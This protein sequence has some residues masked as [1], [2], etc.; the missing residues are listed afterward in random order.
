MKVFTSTRDIT[1]LLPRP[2]GSLSIESS[3]GVT[4]VKPNGQATVMERRE[5]LPPK[6]AFPAP[7]KSAGG[8]MITARLPD[9]LAA[10]FGDTRLWL[11]EKPGPEL[12]AHL[13]EVTALAHWQGK[14]VLGARRQGAWVLEKNGW[15]PLT[16]HTS[17]PY[18]HNIQ[19]LAWYRG[20]LYASTLDQGL[21]TL[22]GQRWGRVQG[23]STDAPRQLLIHA[24]RLLVRHGD[25][26]VDAFDG[27]TWTTDTLRANLP[28][29][30][31]SAIATD[32]TR[33]LAL[34]WGGYS[35]WD[36][37]IWSHR[38]DLPDLRSIALTCGLLDNNTFYIGTQ[39]RGLVEVTP[40]GARR[41]DERLGL[42][43]DWLTCLEKTPDGT[44]HA[45]TFVG[46]LAR[47]RPG[48]SRWQALTETRGQQVTSLNAP[49]VATRQR[50]W[51]TSSPTLSQLREVQ[52]LCTAGSAP[53]A[54]TRTALYQA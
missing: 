10:V 38:F 11:G 48:Q 5:C 16:D 27:R 22:N 17:E 19:A 12:P 47:L 1:A 40:T 26:Q 44:L 28:R 9:G 41:H 8:A 49:L 3:G 33:L 36:G 24:D 51:G 34:Q 30:I 2:D 15:Q 42:P 54:G 32:G 50:I 39:G 37:R 14:I 45:G 4:M 18:D 43:D 20:T 6:V 52:A 53:W 13:R 35:L 31:T 7:P 23:L 21:L 46:G 29:K 25:G